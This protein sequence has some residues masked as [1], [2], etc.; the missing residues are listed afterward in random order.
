MNKKTLSLLFFVV[1]ITTII[2]GYLLWKKTQAFNNLVNARKPV[3]EKTT[4]VKWDDIKPWIKKYQDRWTSRWSAHLITKSEL[5]KF[6]DGV[7]YYQILSAKNPSNNEETVVIRGIKEDGSPVYL[8]GYSEHYVLEHTFPCPPC[9]TLS[10]N[11]VNY[12]YSDLD[13]TSN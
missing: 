3:I 11:V 5:D 1:S 6:E 10:G 4:P 9:T 12:E 2:F 7:I 8:Q 13:K